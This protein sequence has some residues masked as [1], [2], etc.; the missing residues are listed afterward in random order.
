[1]RMACVA[2]VAACLRVYRRCVD[3][4]VYAEHL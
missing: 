3:S 1:M 2:R 4:V